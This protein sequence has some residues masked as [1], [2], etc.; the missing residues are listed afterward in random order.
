MTETVPRD[1]RAWFVAHCVVDLV[2]AVPLLVAPVWTV[3]LLG[4]PTVDPLTTR[5][6]GAAL[7][8]IGLES[9]LGRDAPPIVYR[10]MLNLKIIWA[11]AATAGITWT[12]L[13][14]GPAVGWAFA[15]VF[16]AFGVVW[17]RYRV[18]LT[19]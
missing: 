3:G 4:W 12:M 17:V 8:A 5:L 10:A 7:L 1:L 11:S 9:W 19:P 16:A 13:D 18:A 6:V 14:G 15:A 2:F